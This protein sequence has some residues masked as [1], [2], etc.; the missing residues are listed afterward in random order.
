MFLW[1]WALPLL[2]YKLTIKFIS[3]HRVVKQPVLSKH[4]EYVISSAI[5]ETLYAFHWVPTFRA[6]IALKHI[7]G[8]IICLCMFDTK[9]RYYNAES[10]SFIASLTKG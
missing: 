4:S 3:V 6:A 7:F 2:P 1:L 8:S 10:N 5:L 9:N